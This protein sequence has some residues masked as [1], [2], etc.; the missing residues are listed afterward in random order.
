MRTNELFYYQT[1][2][3]SHLNED[4]FLSMSQVNVQMVPLSHTRWV[5]SV[6]NKDFCTWDPSTSSGAP[7]A[8]FRT[9][10]Q[11]G[12]SS[13]II[14]WLWSLS[15]AGLYSWS[16]PEKPTLSAS[17]WIWNLSSHHFLEWKTTHPAVWCKSFT[18]I[19]R[20]IIVLSAWSSHSG[21][22]YIPYYHW[23]DFFFYDFNF[24]LS[25]L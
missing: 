15:S 17:T 2:W 14:G 3:L 11:R 4:L 16:V 19:W 18:D 8:Q 20:S 13:L 10:V 7:V 23:W 6:C 21:R 25:S 1:I 22:Q 9:W 5:A 24:S 12:G